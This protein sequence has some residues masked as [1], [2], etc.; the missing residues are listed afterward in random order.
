MTPYSYVTRLLI[1][2][3]AILLSFPISA[4]TL[5]LRVFDLTTGPSHEVVSTVS[6]PKVFWSAQ[7][8]V[9][10]LVVK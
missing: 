4:H 9:R 7:T 3:I 2:L 8:T 1:L 10:R 5:T 6:I